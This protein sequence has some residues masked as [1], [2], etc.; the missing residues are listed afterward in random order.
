M[1]MHAL[2][3]AKILLLP[4]LAALLA[5]CPTQVDDRGELP[6]PADAVVIGMIQPLASGS[7]RDKELAAR[8]AVREIN[9]A[10]GVN[11]RPL[12]LRIVYDG[13]N[14]PLRGVAAA[15]E[16][17]AA[18]VVAIIGANASRV[19]LPVAE[20][21]TI[22]A[23]VAL[24]SPGSTSPLVSL[25]ADNDT[26]WRIPPSDALQGRLL[27]EQVWAEGRSSAALFLLDEPYGRGLAAA[28]R[29]RFE[30]LGGSIHAEAMAPPSRENG[31]ATE[32]ATLYAGGVPPALM[33]FS[34]ATPSV[35]LMREIVTS[36]GSLPPLYGVDA[37]MITDTVQNAPAQAAG[38]RGTTPAAASGSSEFQD[39]LQAFVAATGYVPGSN[40]ENAYDAV[41]LIALALAQA[42]NSGRADVVAQLRAVSRAD[43]PAAVAIGPGQF[44]VAVAAIAGGD[45][46]D[47]QGASGPIDFDAAGDPAAATYLYQEIRSTPAG[48]E[49]VTLETIPY[50]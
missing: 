30:A 15:Q 50:P 3:R 28:F 37:N 45:D 5:G 16:L 11:G 41:Y 29:E 47:Y 10:G 17:V 42:G 32:I 46:I 40:T 7:S 21:V 43:G 26:V 18:G 39:F 9:A 34:F 38:M 36:Q 6:I 35:N 13:N 48:L 12:A 2:A 19:T 25:L 31:F 22:P 1:S 14:D 49:L 20:Q 33:L 27:A 4:W 8:L 23:G 44:A 24:V